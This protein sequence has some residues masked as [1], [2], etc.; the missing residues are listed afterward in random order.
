MP[1]QKKL[2]LNELKVKS[3]VTL[4]NEGTRKVKGGTWTICKTCGSECECETLDTCPTDCGTCVTCQT[5]CTCVTCETCGASCPYS[6]CKTCGPE[7]L[8]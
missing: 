1:K 4:L 3:F 8:P 5:D 6:I 7:C 2:K